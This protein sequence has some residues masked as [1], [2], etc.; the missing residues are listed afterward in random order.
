MRK[1]LESIKGNFP[2]H[3]CLVHS[4]WPYAWHS[5]KVSTIAKSSVRS[6]RTAESR[7]VERGLH[8]C[9]DVARVLSRDA[10][11]LL[12]C[13]KIGWGWGYVWDC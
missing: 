6:G 1:G 11:Y 13:V 7:Q 5:Y 4:T 9:A 2:R 8:C 12:E 10:S 3:A